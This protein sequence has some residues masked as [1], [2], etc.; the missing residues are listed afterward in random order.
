MRRLEEQKE[1]KRR[2]VYFMNRARLPELRRE[3]R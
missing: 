2:K 1:G 3:E